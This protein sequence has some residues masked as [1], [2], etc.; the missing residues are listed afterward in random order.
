[1]KKIL[2]LVFIFSSFFILAAFAVEEITITTYYPSPFGSYKELRSQRVA[3][4]DNYLDG[5][6]YTW[7]ETAGDGGEVKQDVDLIVEDKVG[8]GTSTPN[9]LLQ[10]QDLI[11]F[12]DRDIA[13][14]ATNTYIGYQAGKNIATS[15][16]NNTL[17]GYKA[18]YVDG[19]INSG[20]YNT[21][22]GSFALKS[23]TTGSWNVA[24]GHN[25]LSTNSSGSNNVAVGHSTLISHTSGVDNVA[26]GDNTLSRITDT[27]F[28]TALG[29]FALYNSTGTGNTSVGSNSIKNV[30]SGNNNVALGYGAG[31]GLTS[32]SNNTFIGY[33]AGDNA[34]QVNVNYST[35]IG[36]GAYTTINDEIAIGNKDNILSNRES[37]IHLNGATYLDGDTYFNIN[38]TVYLDIIYLEQEFHAPIGYDTNYKDYPCPAGYI[39]LNGGI[40]CNTDGVYASISE[41]RPWSNTSTSVSTAWR[42]NCRGGT[43]NR[44]IKFHLNCI[45][46]QD[47]P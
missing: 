33:G 37:K 11:N 35:A 19:N 38:K 41:S 16:R 13:T 22:L 1:M 46:M 43:S 39:V 17:V 18:G 23:N 5:A 30:T 6:N 31:N 14:S 12:G 34:N 9:N 36:H 27:S 32:G 45:K 26:I 7:E 29:T 4:G 40:D 3:I 20:N 15:L 44:R 2:A 21:A 10:V 8:I 47:I 28:N 42:G 24:L 25:A